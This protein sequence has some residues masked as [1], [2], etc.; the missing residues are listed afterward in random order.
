MFRKRLKKTRYRK[1]FRQ[2][3]YARSVMDLQ[4]SSGLFYTLLWS[5]SLIHDTSPKPKLIGFGIVSSV[6]RG[7]GSAT[8]VWSVVIA[9]LLECATIHLSSFLLLLRIRLCPRGHPQRTRRRLPPRRSLRV[10]PR[11]LHSRLLHLLLSASSR[12]FR[13]W[14]ISFFSDS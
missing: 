4:G 10:S 5:S 8:G 2:S 1:K 7:A 9:F 6:L 3:N 13:R 11:P 14:F 12:S